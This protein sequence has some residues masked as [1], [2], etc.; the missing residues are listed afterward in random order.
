MKPQSWPIDVDMLFCR[1][2]LIAIPGVDGLLAEPSESESA[3]RDGIDSADRDRRDDAGPKVVSLPKLL[4]SCSSSS[5]G[6]KSIPHD[7]G[8]DDEIER[9]G[10]SR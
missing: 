4:L 9:L 7:W 3:S 5:G 2:L 6:L 1:R 8:L 10:T